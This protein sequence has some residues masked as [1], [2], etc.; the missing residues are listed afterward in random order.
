MRYRF[1]YFVV[2]LQ[3]LTLSCNQRSESEVSGIGV[4]ATAFSS[5][6]V[7]VCWENRSQAD[8]DLKNLRAELRQHIKAQFDRT[9]VKLS[10][11]I[12][13]GNPNSS[14]NEIRVTWWDP[15]EAPSPN[16][17]G[18]SRIGNGRIYAS[19]ASQIASLPQ[20]I[21]SAVRAAPTIAL[22]SETFKDV[23][24]ARGQS[25]ALADMKI[26]ALHEFGH[27]V[28]LLHEH[29][30]QDTT[31]QS[32]ETVQMHEKY[33]KQAAEGL[34]AVQKSIVQTSEFDAN[35]IMN[36]CYISQMVSTGRTIGFTEGDIQTIK[37]LYLK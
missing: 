29:V 31:C 15:N 16:V 22:N 11:W 13:C 5:T 9:V 32:R 28:G 4:G 30:R 7:N 26:Y 17:H 25:V 6:Q 18:Q 2:F 8:L 1:S 3:S 34:T 21:K 14:K 23:S 36:Y 24:A 33:W 35:S 12:D 27:A 19:Q 10:G 37:K 20:R